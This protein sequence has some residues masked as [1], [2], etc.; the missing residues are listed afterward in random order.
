MDVVLSPQ[1]SNLKS[2]D[3]TATDAFISQYSQEID[4]YFTEKSKFPKTSS[5][6]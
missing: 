5:K 2:N 1:L 6:N 4:T 3:I